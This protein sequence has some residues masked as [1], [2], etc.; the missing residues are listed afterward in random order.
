M[1]ILVLCQGGNHRSVAMARVLKDVYKHDAIAGGL[2]HLGQRTRGLLFPWADKIVLMQKGMEL[3]IPTEY[4]F[5]AILC[6]VGPDTYHAANHPDLV[7]QVK[8]LADQNEKTH[9]AAGQIK[10]PEKKIYR[11]L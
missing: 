2:D 10:A 1:Q 4:W 7:A 6:D 8:A 9:W 11:A 5:K 3:Q